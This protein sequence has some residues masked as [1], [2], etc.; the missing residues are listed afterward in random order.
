MDKAFRLVRQ[1]LHQPFVDEEDFL[2]GFH[3]GHETGGGEV[4]EVA[5]GGDAV[6]GAGCL[7]VADFAAGADEDLPDEFL[8]KGAL[9]QL[10]PAF[11][12][13]AREE[14][15]TGIGDSDILAE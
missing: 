11:P 12:D 10:E 8:G 6:A 3:F 13:E 7:E 15:A 5:G 9:G 1:Q 14:V 4:V 2:A